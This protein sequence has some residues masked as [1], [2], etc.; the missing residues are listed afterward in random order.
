MP[1]L[2][3]PPVRVFYEVEGP[4]DGPCVTLLN[5]FSR[6]STDFRAM[7]RFLA[8]K[9]WRVLR[10]DNRGAGKTESPD[11]FKATDLTDDVVGVWDALGID[12]SHVLGISYGGV[13]TLLT[14]HRYS[15]RVRSI[16]LVST[17]PS[18]FF[19]QFDNYLPSQTPEE[20]ETYLRRYFSKR[21][22]EQN[23]VLFRSLLKETAKAFL[24]PTLR[25]R[26]A[27]QRA[28]LNRF[29]FTPLLLSIS[30]PA[31]IIHGEEDLVVSPEAAEIAHR[32]LKNSRLEMIPDV[33]HLL[34]AEVPK[35]FYER[36]AAFLES[37]R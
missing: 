4:A 19:L 3:K 5:G 22:T 6:S 20:V 33:G 31:L 10:I 30:Q 29:D 24:D 16:V 36:V 21:F 34:L 12:D 13:L 11:G 23:P 18:S 14:A 32:S 15:K 25:A 28:A 26:A 9:G 8:E 1:Y 2:D 35:L 37:N 27:Q 17:T 7:S